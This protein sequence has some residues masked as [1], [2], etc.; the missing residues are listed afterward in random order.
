MKSRW[1]TRFLRI[2]NLW[3]RDDSCSHTFTL[4]ALF[5]LKKSIA[6]E[7]KTD[8]LAK[9]YIRDFGAIQVFAKQS[10]G[11]IMLMIPTM[12]RFLSSIFDRAAAAEGRKE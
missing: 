9:H 10:S 6:L 5:F 3:P 8:E 12:R 2:E 7:A 1:S 11:P 4:F